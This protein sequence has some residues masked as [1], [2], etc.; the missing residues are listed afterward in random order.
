MSSIPHG[1][2][3]GDTYVSRR[4]NVTKDNDTDAA[5][6][7]AKGAS[8]VSTLDR[9]AEGP[10]PAPDP[11]AQPQASASDAIE[12]N[13]D[14]LAAMLSGAMG[15]GAAGEEDW[16]AKTAVLVQTIAGEV[17]RMMASH[18]DF[19]EEEETKEAAAEEAATAAA[20][21]AAQATFDE[22]QEVESTMSFL[23]DLEEKADANA[24]ADAQES[25]AQPQ[26][27]PQ[28]TPYDIWKRAR[29]GSPGPARTGKHLTEAQRDAVSRRLYEHQYTQ[30]VARR[31]AQDR[32]LQDE[33][34]SLHFA[35]CINARSKKIAK[36]RPLHERLGSVIEEK[37]RKLAL[38]RQRLEA[39][40]LEGCTGSPQINHSRRWTGKG[41]ASHRRTA[42]QTRSQLH[43]QRQAEGRVRERPEPS[44][45]E[46]DM[47]FAPFLNRK[48]LRMAAK[49]GR[50]GRRRPIAEQ[51]A[52]HADD[53]ESA[54][55]K[56][57]WAHGEQPTFQPRI[58]EKSRRIAA[59]D[60]AESAPVH[61]R[62]YRK[63]RPGPG[64]AAVA[65][66]AMAVSPSQAPAPPPTSPSSGP[67]HSRAANVFAF[68]E[69][70]H[71]F[72]LKRVQPQ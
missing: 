10:G 31:T 53:R 62:L 36:V 51:A 67:L 48:S 46:A 64:L 69:D 66:A 68:R 12:R 49:A 47:T 6:P 58:N 35:P 26:P 27:Q 32:A 8:E 59:K 2:E 3:S 52:A 44:A 65:P 1:D 61:E 54:R 18:A 70:R 56:E 13:A 55:R 39:V 16:T 21:A 14:A 24:N 43:T 41:A 28:L 37:Q 72:L 40:E 9:R 50:Q 60:A 63:R 25:Q 5:P 15:V 4:R 20:A 45:E 11:S 23:S 57:E 7:A 42:S 19:V 30:E 33:L 17:N 38:E 71:A 29:G 34:E 22:L